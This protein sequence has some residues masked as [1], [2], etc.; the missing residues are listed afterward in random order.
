MDLVGQLGYSEYGGS[1]SGNMQALGRFDYASGFLGVE[2]A[3]S[4]PNRSNRA[5]LA[6]SQLRRTRAEIDLRKFEQSIFL[7]L[8][9]AAKRVEL[10]RKR[11]QAAR[12]AREL[13]EVSLH[14]EGKRLRAG[15]SRMFF[16]LELQEDLAAAQIRELLASSDCS[17]AVAEYDRQLGRTLQRHQIVIAD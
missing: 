16:V 10:N 9:T 8:E 17:K 1:L 14:A 6:A 13:A 3:W 12:K 5:R 7:Q 2:A 15:T 11:I 4:I